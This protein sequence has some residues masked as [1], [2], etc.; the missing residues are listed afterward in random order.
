VRDWFIIAPELLVL[1]L[2][3]GALFTGRLPDG[4]RLTARLAA[5]GAAVAGVA[6]FVLPVSGSLFGSMLIFTPQ[7]AVVRAAVAGLTA[8]WCAWVAG[9]GLGPRRSAEAV[10]LVLFS[11][12]GGMLL[13]SA[14]DL[15]TLVLAIELSTMPAYVLVGYDREDERSLEAALKYFLMSVLT[16]LFA[17][18]GLSYVFGLAGTTLYGGLDIS[19]AGALGLM[20]GIFTLVGLFAKLSAVPFHFWAP[21]AYEGA[22][23]AIVGFVSTVPKVA[24]L[25]A[26]VNIF[27]ALDPKGG[28]ALAWVALVVAVASMILGNLGAYPQGD[29]RRLMAYSGI[30]HAGYL[31]L[32]VAAGTLSALAAAVLYAVVYAIPS[33]GVMLVAGEEGASIDAD[34]AGLAQRRPWVAWS[35]VAFLMSLIGVPPFAGFF[36]KLFLFSSAWGAGLVWPVVLALVMSVVSAGFYFRIIR[37]AF[38]GA[39]GEERAPLAP[40]V[41]AGVALVT[42]LAAV[43]LLGL[44]AQPIMTFV[45]AGLP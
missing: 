9:R 1:A 5:I 24:G 30:A 10:S 38:F 40:S 12:L 37:A 22:D 16:S 31:A 8:V 20:A 39:P 19:R 29:L 4:D 21:D 33:M 18:F 7:A 45:S 2:A 15:I 44:M 28:G 32:G 34:L 13:A 3:A 41:W 36:G 14:G 42:C 17:F 25:A 6:I 23:P 43:L 35:L 11:A 27:H 26:L